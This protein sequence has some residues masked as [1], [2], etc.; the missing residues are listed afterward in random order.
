M[1]GFGGA[2][3]NYKGEIIHLFYGNMG[4]NSKNSAELEGLFVGLMIVDRKN[5]LSI[6]MEGDLAIIL[7]LA[8]EI[9]YGMLVSEV[10]SSWCLA[11]GLSCLACLL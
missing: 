8:T 10:T 7:S 9:L 1:A 2:I 6:N 11:H 4:F 3:T 5:I